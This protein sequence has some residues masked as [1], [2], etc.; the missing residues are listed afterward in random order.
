MKSLHRVLG[1]AASLALFSAHLLAE[2]HALLI[3]VELYE[4]ADRIAPLSAANKDAREL[5]KA[6]VEVSGFQAENVRILT[7]DGTPKP[8]RRNIMFEVGQL[9][10]RVKPDDV[11]FI[12]FS[13]H[14]LQLVD[15]SYLIP[16]DGDLRNDIAL[17]ASAI[18]A[19]DLRSELRKITCK[20]LILAFDMCRNLPAKEAAKN[21]EGSNS[22]GQRQAKDLTVVTDDTGAGPK[23]VVTLFSSSPLQRSWEWRDRERG[24]FSYFLEK[25]LRG[26]AAD[27][28]G[29]VQ[30]G[31]LVQYLERAVPSAVAR[32]VNEEQV[33]FT[34]TSGTG[35]LSIVLAE[36]RPPS[37]GGRQ[38][39]PERTGDPD[40]DAY[41]AAFQRG[42]QLLQ[43]GRFDAAIERFEEAIAANPTG[44][45]AYAQIGFAFQ[46][47]NQP[48]N[49]ETAYSKALQ[50]D[51]S[52]G[53]LFNSLG[54]VQEAQGNHDAAE[55]SYREAIRIDPGLA[56]P[57]NNLAK[58]LWMVR[59]ETAEA[60]TLF[61]RAHDLD[62]N[63][64]AILN[65]LGVVLRSKGKNDEAEVYFRKAVAIAPEFFESTFNLATIH[66]LRK[67][68][69]E[70]ERLYKKSSELSPN[71]ARPYNQLGMIA[72]NARSNFSEAEGLF[73]K[74][75]QLD[76]KDG[77]TR[78]NWA[79]ALL[80]LGQKESAEQQARQA[81]ALG[82]R[83]P[84]HPAFK[85][86]GIQPSR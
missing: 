64:P 86:L 41:N 19:D 26:E 10:E 58:L 29:V 11:V 53:R 67:E 34:E 73:R 85:E 2:G 54:Q 23:S 59:N 36:G 14:G 76:P 37:Q 12:F 74:S 42:M 39:E 21:A 28:N 17:K 56:G 71:D 27:A 20:S 24:F 68:Y 38:V 78:A 9:V 62:P 83:D 4:D 44:A 43:Q 48:G 77:L 5:G 30:V 45:A 47:L 15:G 52:S 61:K 16:F 80:R 60:E 40:K 18:S 50:I 82:Y 6:L 81:I 13:G 22:L 84:N 70:A 3:G 65:N 51:N 32:E 66:F 55:K 7:S 57:H 72:V 75:A 1:A 49:A 69:A 79:L 25:G 46:Q 33:P 35:A 63:H 31:N 8:S